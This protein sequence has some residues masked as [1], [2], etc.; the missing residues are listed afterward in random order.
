MTQTNLPKLYDY[1]ASA[2]CYKARLLEADSPIG[3]AEGLLQ[4]RG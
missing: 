2:N 4:R 1:G 3:E